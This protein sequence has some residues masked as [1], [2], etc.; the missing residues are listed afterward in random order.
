MNVPAGIGLQIAAT[1]FFALMS[2]LVRMVA[3]EVPSGEI[4][5]A[6]SFFGLVPVVVWLLWSGRMTGA[7][8]TRQPLGHVVRGLVGVSA[9]WLSFAAL[10]FIPLAEAVAFSYATP[11]VA[12]VLA[13]LL[14]GERVPAYRWLVLAVGFSGIVIMLWPSFSHAAVGTG[15]GPLI[16]A[17]LALIGAVGAGFAITQVRHL[18]RTETSE[19]IVFYFSLVASLAGLAT[20]PLGWVVPDGRVALILVG[21]GLAGGV[22]Q[23][24]VT[25]AIRHAPASVVAPFNYA[26]LLWATGFGIVLFGEWP[27]PLVVVGALVVVVAGLGLI[28]RERRPAPRIVASRLDPAAVSSGEDANRVGET[29][30]DTPQSARDDAA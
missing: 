22:G 26:L 8:A 9:M 5:F 24:C 7:L 29:G 17:G 3:D 23:I 11:L 19:A 20:L 1:F 12:V 21:M 27:E 2:A 25:A 4:V 14:L 15:P 6:R 13:A 18:T 30:T 28:W 10:A 16:G